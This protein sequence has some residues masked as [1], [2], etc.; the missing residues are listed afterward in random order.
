M[1]FKKTVTAL[2]LIAAFTQIQVAQAINAT[3]FFTINLNL[4]KHKCRKFE[5]LGK[6]QY[7]CIKCDNIMNLVQKPII[8]VVYVPVT[9]VIVQKPKLSFGIGFSL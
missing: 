3:N 8:P 9:P 7:R 4:K 6:N 2:F 5:Y 1:L